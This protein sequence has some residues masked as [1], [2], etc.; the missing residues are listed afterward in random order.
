M[1]QHHE[2]AALVGIDWSDTKP[3]LCLYECET[4]ALEM[5]VI[6]HQPEA[7]EQWARSLQQRF[8]GK[9]IAVCLEQKRGPLIYALCKYDF[10]FCFPSIPK[11]LPS[12]VKPS[13][14]VGQKMTRLTPKC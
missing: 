8:D 5:S 6:V 9:P 11:A 14:P 4:Q 10:W 12:P 13:R 2:F 1:T 7:S 3:E